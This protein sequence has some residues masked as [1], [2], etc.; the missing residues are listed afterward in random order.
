MGTVIRDGIGGQ[1]CRVERTRL[2]P[3]WHPET[4]S[5][6]IALVKLD[7]V[8]S[9]T[10][11]IRPVT[12]AKSNDE[13]FGAGDFGCNSWFESSSFK[14]ILKSCSTPPDSPVNQLRS[15]DNEPVVVTGF[16]VQGGMIF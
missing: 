6:D 11:K 12:L 2:H 13:L 7:C 5:Y 3:D 9:M 15:K 16:G 4:K 1:T 14:W 8:V 10:D